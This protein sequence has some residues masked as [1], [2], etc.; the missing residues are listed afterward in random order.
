[1]LHVILCIG[2]L[3]RLD[4]RFLPL[5][6]NRRHLGVTTFCVALAH[7]VI[8]VGYYHGFGRINPLL[9]LLTSNTNYASVSAFPFQTLGLIALLILFLMAATSHDFWNRN[10]GPRAWKSIHMLIYPA[11]ALLVMHVVLGALQA[12]R[13]VVL[14]AML[15]AG[16]ATVATL[17]LVAGV[18]EYRRGARRMGG[19]RPGGRHH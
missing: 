4:P 13:S 12:Q 6:Y 15:V 19:L 11:Y 7:A 9:S 1:M 18:R 2:P 8:A 10:L 5:L 3:A 17:Q 16:V 14:A